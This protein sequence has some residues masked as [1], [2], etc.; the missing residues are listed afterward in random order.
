MMSGR[1]MVKRC[2]ILNGIPF[3]R[4]YNFEDTYSEVTERGHSQQEALAKAKVI[5]V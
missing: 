2:L 4:Y 1:L 3:L 5:E